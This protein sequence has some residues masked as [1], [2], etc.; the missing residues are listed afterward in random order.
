MP[1]PKEK[2]NKTIL[3]LLT[4]NEREEFRLACQYYGI[5]LST[6]FRKQAIFLIDRYKNDIN[7]T[8][9]KEIENE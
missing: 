3:V 2:K 7:V 5:K 1:K 6:Y 8:K 4:E 9:Q